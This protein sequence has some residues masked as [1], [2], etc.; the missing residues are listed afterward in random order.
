MPTQKQRSLAAAVELLGTQGV[1]ALTHLRIDRHAGL[2]DGTTSNYFRTRAALLRGVGDH[3]LA[4]ELP[5]VRR[6][7]AP[8]GVADLV[9]QLVDLFE[10]MTGP[11]RVV[12]AARL[13]M[14]VEAGHDD[15]LR[16]VLAGGRQTIEES[17]LPAY[18]ALGAPDPRLAV[19]L[20]ATCF[21]GLFLHRIARHADIDPRPVIDLVVRAGLRGAQRD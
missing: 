20:L 7:L 2:P 9:D 19:D 18:A 10:F 5:E 13:A 21:E 14:I 4:S 1:R 8:A 15:E 3:M 11:N 6:A 17:V 16:H 12:T